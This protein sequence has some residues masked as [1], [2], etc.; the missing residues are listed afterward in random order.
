MRQRFDIMTVAGMALL[1]FFTASIVRG[2]AGEGD[3]S[4]APTNDQ[5]TPIAVMTP[6]PEFQTQLDS[7][8]APNVETDDPDRNLEIAMPYADYFLT[9]G[10]HGQS[11]GH[12]AIDISG[13]KGETIHS[14]IN[15]SVTSTGYDQ[16]GNTYIQIENDNYIVLYLH[17]VY[18]LGVGEQVLAGQ[19]IGSEGNIGYTLDMAGN[20]CAGRDCGYHTHLNVFDKRLGSNIDPLSLIPANYP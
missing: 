4:A 1:L 15:G 12:F 11:Y 3:P 2:W 19:P 18:T 5:G 17:G 20:S 9:Q 8:D 7:S 16:W 14:I 10:I 13:G 6:L